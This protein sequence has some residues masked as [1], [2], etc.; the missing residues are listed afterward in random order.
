MCTTVSYLSKRMAT[1]GGQWHDVLNLVAGV[2]EHDVLVT[3]TNVSIVL[4]DVDPAGNVQ[5]LI[6]D[7]DEYFARLVDETLT[8]NGGEVVHKAVV[9]NIGNR[10][11]DNA[12]IVEL[13]LCQFLPAPPPC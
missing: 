9:T 8:S 13:R 12:I 1:D 11:A 10:L 2:A 5:T 3:G 6:V 4:A 7:A